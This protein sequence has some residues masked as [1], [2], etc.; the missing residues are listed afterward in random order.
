VRDVWER[1][2]SGINT[3]NSVLVDRYYSDFE[4]AFREFVALNA[5]ADIG[6]LKGGY[7]EGSQYGRAAVAKIHDK[8]PVPSFEINGENAPQELGSNYIQ[9]IPTDNNDNKL[10]LEF[11]GSDSNN[12]TTLI[13]K[14]KSDG[15]GFDREEMVLDPGQRY[16]CHTI[17][18]F[19]STYSEVFLAAAVLVDHTLV[20]TA[21]YYYK[22][23]INGAC[24]DA[25]AYL[26]Q[27]DNQ[28]D[29]IDKANSRRCFIATAAFGSPGST[30]VRILRDF[31]DKYLLPYRIGQSFVNLYYAVSPAIAEF[32][33]DHP[34][35]SFIVRIALLPAV[36][37]AFLFTKTTLWWNITLIIIVLVTWLIP[38]RYHG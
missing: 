19:G 20:E 30:S 1:A 35:T 25:T 12:W 9:F 32:I 31:R 29:V 7:E 3:I 37:I 8:Y 33:E 2:D 15:T 23:S 6:E 5:V 13:V 10:V 18:G 14:V 4:S 27:S 21:P 26:F 34:P 28:P 38:Y 24:P 17:E 16:G 22:A 36:A 11:D